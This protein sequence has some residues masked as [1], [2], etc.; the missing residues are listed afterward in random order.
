[1]FTRLLLFVLLI[2][3]TNAE[4]GEKLSHD[5][6]VFSVQQANTAGSNNNNNVVDAADSSIL[7]RKKLK[8]LKRRL[9]LDADQSQKKQ[10]AS[11]NPLEGRQAKLR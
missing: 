7:K 11:F 6:E 9:L 8:K 4:K 3:V 5:N 1:M 2:A 10:Q